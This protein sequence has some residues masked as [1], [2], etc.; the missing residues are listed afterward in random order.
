MHAAPPSDDRLDH[1]VR[2][3][4]VYQDVVLAGRT[5]RRGVRD[6]NARWELLRDHF[7]PLG[8]VLDVGS[9]FGWF[10]VRLCEEFDRCVV[11]SIE[12]DERTA[13]I[14]RE[15]LGSHRLHRVCLLTRRATPGGLRRLAAAN[16][17]VDAALCL[18]VLHWLPDPDAFLVALGA[19]AGRIFVEHP[20]PG[21]GAGGIARG[22]RK[23]GE[24]GVYLETR[25]PGRR[26]RL[27]GRVPS[28]L[29]PD[30][31]RPLWMVEEP[32]GWPPAPV[33]G[34]GVGAL[35]PMSVSWP[36]RSWWLNQL[37]QALADRGDVVRRCAGG[38]GARWTADGIT[39]RGGPLPAAAVRSLRRKLQRVPEHAPFTAP[40]RLTRRARRA[41]GTLLRAAHLRP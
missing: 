29:R 32:P 36:P 15:V 34:I 3:T 5:V 26:V 39:Y 18:S 23:I 14:Q 9:N 20:D 27:L 35:L 33:P 1:L 22:Q 31:M 25:F 7:P 41:A 11:A 8:T 30:A 10:G 38:A 37:D 17:R 16:Q 21:E 13:V 24:I 19:I 28:H 4:A 40:Q 2:G 6:C 12:A